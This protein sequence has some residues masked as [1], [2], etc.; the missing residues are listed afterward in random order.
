MLS[1][2]V[3]VNLQV[4]CPPVSR[5]DITESGPQE[6]APLGDKPWCLGVSWAAPPARHLLGVLISQHWGGQL[7]L[8]SGPHL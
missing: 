4:T 6:D 2:P 8:A 5:S 3:T 7:P 1:Q